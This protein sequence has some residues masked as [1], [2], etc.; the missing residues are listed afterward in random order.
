MTVVVCCICRVEV[1]ISSGTLHQLATA[2]R[3]ELAALAAKDYSNNSLLQQKKQSL[4]IDMMHSCN[5][6]EGLLLPEDTAAR[7]A[8]PVGVPTCP[9]DWAWA[10]QLKYYA[11]AVSVFPKRR[12]GPQLQSTWLGHTRTI[13][14]S[15][16][17]F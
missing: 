17:T 10:R 6:V 3:Q 7:A 1:A 9:K 12:A 16:T 4:I 11:D 5:V 2:L 13:S 8:G 15:G 14:G